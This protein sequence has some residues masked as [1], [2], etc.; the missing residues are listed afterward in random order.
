MSLVAI[1]CAFN[2]DSVSANDA[3][4]FIGAIFAPLGVAMCV[5]PR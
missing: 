2:A 1:V 4:I 3:L 5:W